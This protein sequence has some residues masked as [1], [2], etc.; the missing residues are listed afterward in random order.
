MGLELDRAQAGGLRRFPERTGLPGATP[1][2]PAPAGVAGAAGEIGRGPARGPAPADQGRR[3]QP[4]TALDHAGK[5]GGHPGPAV[6]RGVRARPHGR[7][8]RAA[9]PGRPGRVPPGW[10]VAAPVLAV[11]RPGRLARRARR[12]RRAGGGGQ[13][14]RH[15]H[16]RAPG[17]LPC[18]WASGP[19]QPGS[20]IPARAD[21]D[22]SAHG[23]VRPPGSDTGGAG[24]PHP[25]VAEG[26][27]RVGPIPFPQARPQ[28]V[29]PRRRLPWRT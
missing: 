29:S 6:L 14:P 15:P 12:G 27:V 3:R 28:P 9:G 25:G 20:G 24:R 4:G 11:R 16:R 19:G 22:G 26:A 1:G 13:P 8:A 2:A 17:P 23:P 18:T 7:A 5:P 21:G 10:R